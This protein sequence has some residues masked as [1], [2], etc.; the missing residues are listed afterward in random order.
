MLDKIDYQLLATHFPAWDKLSTKQQ[1]ILCQN[2]TLLNAPKNSSLNTSIEG[3]SGVLIIKAGTLRAYTLSEEGREITFYRLQTGDICLLSASCVLPD[4]T[5]DIFIE[6]LSDCDLIQI[7]PCVFAKIMRENI[8]LENLTYKLSTK[9][10]C[11]VICAMQ[12]MMFTSFDKRLASFLLTESTSSSNNEIAMTH[13]QIAKLLGTAREVV[14]RMLKSF[15][16]KNY[17][18][19]TRGKV[20]ILNQQALK[21]I[22]H[23]RS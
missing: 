2:A 18:K 6:S 7:P 9:R 23:K 17:V 11:A 8:Y 4:I 10:L 12:Q 21:Q 3:C 22:L 13:E 5:L 16:K 15:A 20:T 19:L 14:S 1:Q